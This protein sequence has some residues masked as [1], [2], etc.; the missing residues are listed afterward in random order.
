MQDAPGENPSLAW[1]RWRK[2]LLTLLIFVAVGSLIWSQ[3]PR[4]AYPTD[5]TRVGAGLPALVLAF[6]MNY[7]G[8]SEVMELMNDIRADYAGRI[9]FLV[10]NLGMADGQAFADRHAAGDGTGLLFDAAGARIGALH[11]PRGVNELRHALDQA[12]LAD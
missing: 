2:L 5:L 6:D 3:L 10:A 8:G 7:T 1:P 9:E 4:G 12:L 11:R